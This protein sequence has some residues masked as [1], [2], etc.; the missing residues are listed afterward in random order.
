[1]KL[2]KDIQPSNTLETVMSQFSDKQLR[3]IMRN[4]GSVQ[5]TEGC[6]TGCGD[7]GFEAQK[8]VSDYIPR[9]V[10]E[11]LFD[12]FTK[13][14][15]K[16]EP[17]FYHASDSFDYPDGSDGYWGIHELAIEKLGYN[18][19]II[20][21]VPKTNG[22]KIIEHIFSSNRTQNSGSNGNT[23][24]DVISLL[25]WNYKRIERTIKE[26][27]PMLKEEN[28]IQ[29]ES[30][31]VLEDMVEVNF[32]DKPGFFGFF[33]NSDE[34]YVTVKVLK[35]KNPPKFDVSNNSNSIYFF[36]EKKKPDLEYFYSDDGGLVLKDNREGGV[37]VEK[38]AGKKG[39][40]FAAKLP[41]GDIMLSEGKPIG[42]EEIIKYCNYKDEIE[43]E[44][45]DDRRVYGTHGQPGVVSIRNYTTVFKTNHLERRNIGFKYK[46]DLSEK[47][48]GCFNGVL[49]TPKGFFN[50]Q[51]VEPSREHPMGQIMI[52]IL[53]SK[54]VEVQKY[55]RV[56]V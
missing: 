12:R 45:A 38:L 33:R 54:S 4:V 32:V 27:L 49:I 20:T 29:V 55:K 7:C 24:V 52:P 47:G 35:L 6:S 46:P 56:L 43:R 23:F 50:V 21:S 2:V 26:V 15:A 22:H 42:M 34:H 40:L 48:I 14:L 53:P 39:Y 31:Y 10:V 5:L 19:T 37:L 41:Y 25:D 28:Q 11:M 13:E 18:P 36:S 30:E 16:H 1:M 8:H 17:H 51:T 3:K 44:C 9:S